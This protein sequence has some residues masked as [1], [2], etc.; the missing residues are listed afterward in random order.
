MKKEDFE[1][2]ANTAINDGAA[3]VNPIEVT[4][5]RVMGILEKAY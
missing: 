2:I 5:D 1:I 3:I 4:F